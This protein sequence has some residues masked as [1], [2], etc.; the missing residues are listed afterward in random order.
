M[1]RVRRYA[2]GL[3]LLGA[4]AAN[5]S[6]AVAQEPGIV[7][8]Q[9]QS[10]IERWPT[11]LVVRIDLIGR[12]GTL[13]EA[14]ETLE[15]R[16]E[17]AKLQLK[18]LG[19]DTETVEYGDPTTTNVVNQGQQQM[20][21]M[22]RQR[23]QQSGGDIPE[24]LKTP[25]SS[26][27]TL[28]MI[29][30]WK[31]DADEPTKL[32]LSVTKLRKEIEEADLAGTKEDEGSLA[33]QELMEEAEAFGFDPYSGE[34]QAKPGTPSFSYAATITEEER[35][36]AMKKAYAAAQTDAEQLA[37]IAGQS[38]GGLKNLA[39][40]SRDASGS[41]GYGYSPFGRSRFVPTSDDPLTAESPAMGKV[42][43]NFMVNA[44]FYLVPS[45]K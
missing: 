24:G 36:A 43:F 1:K 22:I 29:A 42:K 13:Q 45:E 25:E 26:T 21:Q 16:K 33:E 2:W 23:I 3:A 39:G 38:L 4:L 17:A 10:E 5:V 14:L 40:T 15:K 8:T 12:A 41:E 18:T 30:R 9:G 32:L 27:V 37:A 44:A 35:Q 7:T 6:T 34:E 20:Q 28:P 19:A 31:L 11:Q